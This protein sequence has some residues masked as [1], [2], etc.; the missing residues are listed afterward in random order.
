MT[1]VSD[2]PAG[3]VTS[4]FTPGTLDAA[5]QAPDSLP[6]NPATAPAPPAG[7]DAPLFP[8]PPP[9]L[10]ALDAAIQRDIAARQGRG[11]LGMSQIGKADTRTLWLQFRGCLPEEHSPRTERI[12]RLGDAIEQEL[13]RYLRQIPGVE[14]HTTDPDGRQFRFA[15]FGGHFGGSMDGAIHG[16]PEAPKTWHVF[17]AKSVAAKRFNDLEKKGVQAWSQEYF[18]QLQCYMGASGMERALFV[19]YCKDDSR[20]H[21]ERVRFE[22]MTWDGLLA[23][24]Q[25]LLEADT[26]PASSYRDPSWYEAKWMPPITAAVYWGERLPP[27]A[28]CRNCRF[29]APDLRSEDLSAHWLCSMA[30]EEIPAAVVPKGCQWHQWIHALCPLPVVE[31][32]ATRTVYALPDG[33]Q[34][35]NG[36]DDYRSQE[37]AEASKNNFMVLDPIGDAIHQTFDARLVHASEPLT[38]GDGDDEVPF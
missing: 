22:P 2:A 20:I 31:A 33:R 32:D 5:R 36:A 17:E 9:V 6:A 26:P 11:H 29:S 8:E 16:I 14:L 19:A 34:I 35:A 10:A 7:H 28:H 30:G 21:A 27:V 12:F 1:M 23:K 4:L 13:V 18:A 25:R 38:V 3:T 37:L 24:A 15:Y